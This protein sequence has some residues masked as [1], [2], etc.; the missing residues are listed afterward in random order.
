[1][2]LGVGRYVRH[3]QPWAIRVEERSLDDPI[4]SW[5]KTWN[6]DGI[7]ARV[8]DKDSMRELAALG[9]PLVQTGEAYLEDLPSVQPQEKLNAIMAAEHLLERQLRNFGFAG[10]TGLGW[11]EI[12]QDAF[13]GHISEKIGAECSVYRTQR[14]HVQNWESERESLANW[15]RSIPK[16]I[17]ILA[18]Y[19]VLGCELLNICREIEVSV[20]NEVAVIGVDNDRVLCEVSD[21]PLSSVD[22]DQEQIG[23][24][25]AAMLHRIIQGR[26]SK[27]PCHV[28]PKGVV[29]RLSTEMIAIEDFAI[30]AALNYIRLEACCGAVVDDVAEHISMSRRTLERRFK[31]ALGKTVRDE[32]N[33]IRLERAKQL[34]QETDWS[35]ERIGEKSGFSNSSYLYV[36]FK[37]ATGKTPGEYR[38]GNHT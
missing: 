32:I 7:I 19:D 1:M 21:P 29:T 10:V 5:L 17:G 16:P 35:I 15:I 14:P 18:C 33:R 12:R 13:I 31:S 36:A 37:Q 24:E 3:H 23:Y 28:K 20:P 11:S 38:N 9:L 22:Q 30:V 6:G 8:R 27:S 26:K 4:P 2:L 25:A 34:L